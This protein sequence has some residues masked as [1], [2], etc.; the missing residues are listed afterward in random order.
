MIKEKLLSFKNTVTNNPSFTLKEQ[1]GYAG[2]MFGNCMGQ[3]SVQTFA[4]QFF[5]DYMGI[6]TGKMTIMGNILT[7]MGFIS[8][9]VAGNALDTPP[10]PGHRS[11][12]KTILGIM[13]IPFA[14][15]SLLL[16][17]VPSSKVIVNFIWCLVLHIVFDVVDSFYDTSLTAMSLRMT[18]NPNDRKNFYTAATLA[19]ALG[20][21][22]PGWVIPMVVDRMPDANK[23]KWAYFFMALVFCIIGLAMM[24]AP[25]FTLE[26]KVR[27][28]QKP[29]K[30]VIQWDKNTFSALIHNRP[31][32]VL[33]SATL[34]ETIRIISYKLLNYIYKQTFDDYSMKSVV[35]VI[36]G[37]LSYAGLAVVP[38]VGKKFTARTVLS[39]GFGWTGIM[40]TVMS[41]FA[42][43]FSLDKIR[44]NKLIVGVLIGLAGMPNQAISAAKKIVVGD[45]TDYMEW[46]SEKRFGE[47]IH[48]EGLISAVQGL[49]AK[50]FTFVQ[51][52]LYNMLFK[53]IGYKANTFDETTGKSVEAQQSV[54]TLKGLYLMFVFCGMAGNIL[55][56]LTY[57]FDNYSGKKRSEINKELDEMREKRKAAEN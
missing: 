56:S 55:A 44:K 23:E 14:L 43:N 16:F 8:T 25:Y 39:A 13:P 30:S 1:L 32:I 4:D 49:C 12:T 11:A 40:Y 29:K 46:Y 35:D 15:A 52:N 31:F 18:T 53:Q 22:L 6:D 24:Y 57:L 7:A 21:M 9:S 20:S 50:I 54:S 37:V 38:M 47:P 27:V 10:K 5:R 34:F 2:G 36:S 17:I 45:S 3:D 28:Q 41:L 33:Q 26:E 19:S 51:T 42:L 48:S